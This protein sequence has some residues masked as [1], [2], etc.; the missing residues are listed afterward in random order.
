MRKHPHVFT[1]LAF[2]WKKDLQRLFFLVQYIYM[3]KN[4]QS[5]G[6]V[7]QPVAYMGIVLTML[8]GGVILG[9]GCRTDDGQPPAQPRQEAMETTYTPEQVKA[10]RARTGFDEKAMRIGGVVGV[11]TGGSVSDSWISVL[12]AN[13]AM[14]MPSF[15]VKVSIVDDGIGI[16]SE[17][18]TRLT[19][20]FFRVD[21]SR[22]RSQ[23]GTGL[24]LAIVKHILG[25]HDSHLLVESHPDRGSTFGFS[26]PTVRRET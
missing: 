17:H 15:Q 11:G 3:Y 21:T 23:G 8:A 9:A 25:A 12:C 14:P 22:S 10:T 1:F 24:G 19:E 13:E 18:L 5:R 7:E 2:F 6:A 20:R 4:H 26:L 16:A